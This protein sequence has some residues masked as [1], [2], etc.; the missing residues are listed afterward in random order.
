MYN[1]FNQCQRWMWLDA[2]SLRRMSMRPQELIKSSM[3]R[4]KL[5]H[6]WWHLKQLPTYDQLTTNLRLTYD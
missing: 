3:I 2:I 1:S 6:I 4:K 5:E